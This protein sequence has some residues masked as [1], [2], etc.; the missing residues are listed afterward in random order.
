MWIRETSFPV[1]YGNYRSIWEVGCMARHTYCI[2]VSAATP[3]C[4][5]D[6]ARGVVSGHTTGTP[7]LLR[8]TRAAGLL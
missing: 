4:K 3:V 7:R 6:G 1:S 2:K 5:P 8:A